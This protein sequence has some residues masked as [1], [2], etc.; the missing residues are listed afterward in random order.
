[1]TDK[2]MLITKQADWAR[3]INE[4]KAAAEMYISAGEYI[5]AVEIIGDHGWA[6]MCVIILMAPKFITLLKRLIYTVYCVFRLIDLA[7][8]LD[9]ADR[10]AL[11]KC[12][13]YLKKMEQYAHA[14]EVYTKMGDT[15]A[16]VLLRVE[17]KH[18]D[19][20][21]SYTHCISY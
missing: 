5:K 14:A 3:N 10:E 11:S 13:F 16:L 9:K 8:K 6:D 12:A 2:K 19:D 1:M 18:W 21:R 4:P 7:R 15:K 17:A 20:V